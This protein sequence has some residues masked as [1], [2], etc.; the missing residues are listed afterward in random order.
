VSCLLGRTIVI[1]QSDLDAAAELQ[2]ELA[3]E[4]C[5][6]FATSSPSVARRLTRRFHPRA[7][8]VDVPSIDEPGRGQ[9]SVTELARSCQSTHA[10]LV[11]IM[12][13]RRLLMHIRVADPDAVLIKPFS[14]EALLQAISAT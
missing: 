12:G 11:A 4:G 9:R 14:R 8:L 1:L 6:V 13:R 3:A 10:R 5:V 2:D 7:L